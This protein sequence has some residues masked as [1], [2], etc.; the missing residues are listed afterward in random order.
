M[1]N[2]RT[3][4]WRRLLSIPPL[5]VAGSLL[6]SCAAAPAAVEK[7]KVGIV[8]YITFSPFF[9]A[10]E[11]GYFDDQNLDV[12]LV[13]F[14]NSTLLMPALE[15]GQL[16]A[17]GNAP[18][19][20]MFNAINQ[21]GNIKIVAD[22]GYVSPTDCSYVVILADPQWVAE[23]P[24][25]AAEAIRG[26]RFAVDINTFQAFVLETYLGTLGLTL[27]D[28][29]T[30]Y[31]PPPNMIEAAKNGSVDFIISAEPWVTRL[32]D[33]GAM[34]IW[35]PIQEIVPDMQTGFLNYGKRLAGDHP[36]I[37]ER[38]M[39]AYLQGVRRFIQGKTDRNVEIIA[40]YTKL[41]PELLRSICWP[42]MRDDGAVDL[43]TIMD[44]Q[45]W[46]VANGQLSEVAGEDA[47][48]DSRFVDF[49]NKQLG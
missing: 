20:G 34:A 27:D 18:V 3:F 16:D 25:P 12:E 5:V 9:I 35:K 48:W 17:A 31:I 32:V 46:A 40:E 22:R 6:S 28:V 33:T 26:M 30:Q 38:F 14:E 23:N 7:V 8:T 15:Q 42:A 4:P 39:V 24:D 13:T 44:Y 29:Q 47:V 41:D 11:E 37:G 21:T 49:A 2:K 1:F 19:A 43:E 36:E 45:E 10:E